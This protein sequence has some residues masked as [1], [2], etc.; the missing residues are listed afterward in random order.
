MSHRETSFEHPQHMFWLRNKKNNFLVQTL[1]WRLGV[2]GS[3]LLG[4]SFNALASLHTFAA[5]RCDKYQ[6]LAHWP[7]FVLTERNTPKFG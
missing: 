6:N 4:S 1:I 3:H 2:L 5:Q 7:I